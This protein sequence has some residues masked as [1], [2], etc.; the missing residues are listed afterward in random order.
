VSIEEDKTFVRRFLEKAWNEGDLS[1]IDECLAEDYVV[2]DPSAI[3]RPPGPDVYRQAVTRFRAA[4]PD[5]HTTVEDMI[6]EGDR[7]AVRLTDR[8]TPQREWM[9]MA[10][11][12]QPVTVTAM[13]IYRLADGKI[14]EQWVCG[15]S[16]GPVAS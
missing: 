14:A 13:C 4:C 11:T 8:F 10:P 15:T 12:G 2:H 6:A 16:P 9:G 5:L 1:V 3:G 7:V